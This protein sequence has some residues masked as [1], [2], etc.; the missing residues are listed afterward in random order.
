MEVTNLRR[1]TDEPM[2]LNMDLAFRRM[3]LVGCSGAR[4]SSARIA[5]IPLRCLLSPIIRN[6]QC[7]DFSEQLQTSVFAGTISSGAARRDRGVLAGKD[8][9]CFMPLAPARACAINLPTSVQGG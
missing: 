6:P 4:W 2:A 5:G 9:W 7:P 3:Q 1:F 8:V